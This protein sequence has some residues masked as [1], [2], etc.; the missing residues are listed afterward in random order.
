MNYFLPSLLKDEIG[1]H[2]QTC[3]HKHAPIRQTKQH[4]YHH[5]LGGETY[6][7]PKT[8]KKEQ[9]RR[10]ILPV[11]YMVVLYY[12]MVWPPLTIDYLTC[13]QCIHSTYVLPASWKSKKKSQP[14]KSLMIVTASTFVLPW[15]E[16]TRVKHRE[17]HMIVTFYY[18]F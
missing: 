9:A 14:L 12:V 11:K 3:P 16:T 17:K 10:C 5:H 7:G 15:I 18:F 8:F 2:K 13:I 4:R 6:P 1:M